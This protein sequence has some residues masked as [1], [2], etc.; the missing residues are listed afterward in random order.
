MKLTV[1]RRAE[2]DARTKQVQLKPRREEEL[3]IS[4]AS[5]SEERTGRRK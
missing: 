2:N 4:G 3:A 1:Q 5:G